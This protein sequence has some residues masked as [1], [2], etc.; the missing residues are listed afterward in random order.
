MQGKSVSQIYVIYIY[1]R[2]VEVDVQGATLSKI[3]K[4]NKCIIKQLSVERIAVWSSTEA[5]AM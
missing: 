3:N 5:I 2:N 4:G 1:K